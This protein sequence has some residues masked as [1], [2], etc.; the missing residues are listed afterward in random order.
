MTSQKYSVTPTPAAFT[1]EREQALL[2]A[3]ATLHGA[4]QERIGAADKDDPCENAV[5]AIE[6]ADRLLDT[7]GLRLPDS[8]QQ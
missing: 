2:M 4:L 6:D 3:V 8:L 5:A 1:T 7:W